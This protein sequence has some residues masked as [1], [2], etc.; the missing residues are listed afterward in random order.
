MNSSQL[1]GE[2]VR[3]GIAHAAAD[4]PLVVLLELRDQR[5][6]VAVAGEEREGVDVGLGVAQ[7]ERVHDHADV[8]AVLAAH[9]GLRDVDHLEAVHVEFLHELPVAR[10]VAVGALGD[11]ASLLEQPLQDELDVEPAALQVLGAER[12]VLEVDE[13]GERQLPAVDRILCHRRMVSANT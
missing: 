1:A 3:R 7:V 2:Q 6:E 10:P 5:R 13:H 8:G 9:L 4:D 12:E 11:D